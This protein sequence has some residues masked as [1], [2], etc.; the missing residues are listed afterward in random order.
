MHAR[1]LT[2]ICALKL[3][4][5]CIGK[6]WMFPAKYIPKHIKI[7]TNLHPWAEKLYV[8]LK[9]NEG[10]TEL[11]QKKYMPMMPLIDVNP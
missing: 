8:V 7:C 2:T 1:I 4:S 10:C 6:I 3:S 11:A 5:T 9:S